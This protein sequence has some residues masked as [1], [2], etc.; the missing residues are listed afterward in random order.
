MAQRTKALAALKDPGSTP[1]TC[2]CLKLKF[3]ELQ[4]PPLT[5]QILH[6]N[7]GHVY[8]Q[9][10]HPHIQNLTAQNCKTCTSLTRTK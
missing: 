9:R 7:G 5:M 4:H 6:T 2:N 8:K 1:S 10:N 3:Q